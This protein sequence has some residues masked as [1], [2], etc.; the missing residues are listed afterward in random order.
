MILVLERLLLVEML[1][2]SSDA[3]SLEGLPV[4][5][6]LS[7]EP[8]TIELE[9]DSANEEQPSGHQT[10]TTEDQHSSSIR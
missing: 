2:D 6:T 4:Q 8:V 9:E 7:P 10:G 3:S 1:W 5:S